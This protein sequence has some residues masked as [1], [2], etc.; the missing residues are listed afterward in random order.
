MPVINRTQQNFLY[1]RG[2]EPTKVRNVHTCARAFPLSHFVVK[3]VRQLNALAWKKCV[4]KKPYKCNF[5]S[6]LFLYF[7]SIDE[8]C[9]IEI[10]CRG[11]KKTDLYTILFF[12]FVFT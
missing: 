1:D 7:N 9:Y 4:L 8:M 2:I 6:E 11:E 10:Q 5:F 12:F 3:N